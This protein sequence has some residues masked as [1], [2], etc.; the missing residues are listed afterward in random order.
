MFAATLTFYL[1]ILLYIVYSCRAYCASRSDILQFYC[2]ESD[3]GSNR[4]Q[5]CVAS[6][7]AL[8]HYVSMS[9]LEGSLLDKGPAFWSRFSVRAAL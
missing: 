9:V 6:L 3:V 7:A 5:A 4:A 2:S 1:P 8:N